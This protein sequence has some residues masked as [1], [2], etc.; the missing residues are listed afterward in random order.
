MHV[1]GTR[2]SLGRREAIAVAIAETGRPGEVRGYGEIANAPAAVANL[3]KKVGAWHGKLHFVYEAGPSGD[4][5]QRQINAAGHV[6]DVV[7]L[8]HTPRRAGDRVKTD[9]QDAVILA[10]LSRARELK[11]VWARTKRKDPQLERIVRLAR[12]SEDELHRARHWRDERSLRQLTRRGLVWRVCRRRHQALG[13]SLH[14]SDLAAREIL[15]VHDA[16]HASR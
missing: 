1:D 12:L 6:R 10:R 13:H 5:L 2:A 16:M 8:A 11:S 14:Q 3:L 7:L 4:G 15:L 9:R